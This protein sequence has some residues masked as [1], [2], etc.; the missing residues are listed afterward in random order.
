MKGTA[1]NA[2][3]GAPCL[4]ETGGTRQDPATQSKEKAS[5]FSGRNLIEVDAA[6]VRE[7]MRV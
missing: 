2:P 1:S 5:L 6:S 4:L 7:T 3:S